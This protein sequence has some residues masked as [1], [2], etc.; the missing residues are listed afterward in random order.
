MVLTSIYVKPKTLDF[1]TLKQGKTNKFC[2][3]FYSKTLVKM[4]L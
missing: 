2:N 3:K 4:L 1:K